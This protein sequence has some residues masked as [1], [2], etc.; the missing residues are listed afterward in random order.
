MSKEKIIEIIKDEVSYFKWDY[1]VC[2]EKL[3]ELK[4]TIDE[5][6]GNTLFDESKI[7]NTVAM[8]YHAF[9]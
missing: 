9:G 1:N 8:A 4:F 6:V 2:M 7:R 3:K 5:V